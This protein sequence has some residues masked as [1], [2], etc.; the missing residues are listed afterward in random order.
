MYV[1]AYVSDFV[2]YYHNKASVFDK[3]LYG[4]PMAQEDIMWVNI[5]MRLGPN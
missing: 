2:G 4:I 5:M 1:Y 3:V